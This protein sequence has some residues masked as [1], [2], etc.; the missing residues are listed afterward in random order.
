MSGVLMNSW[1]FLAIKIQNSPHIITQL[2]TT[3]YTFTHIF[4]L[5]LHKYCKIEV[6]EYVIRI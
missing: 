4:L 2:K 1:H 3:A 5:I 6:S